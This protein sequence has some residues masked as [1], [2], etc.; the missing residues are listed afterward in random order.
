[1]LLRVFHALL[2][3]ECVQWAVKGGWECGVMETDNVND[4]VRVMYSAL[5][6]TFTDTKPAALGQ[7]TVSAWSG[8]QTSS[9]AGLRADVS[10]TYTIYIASL[11]TFPH[12]LLLFA[13]HVRVREEWG[14]G[15]DRLNAAQDVSGTQTITAPDSESFE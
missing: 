15:G 1:M 8:L 5:S 14:V 12:P 4:V 2:E 9:P 6:L 10:C 13:G 3:T 7:Q 11:S